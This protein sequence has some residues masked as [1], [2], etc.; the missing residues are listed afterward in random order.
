MVG[1]CEL[2]LALPWQD[3]YTETCFIDE[4][5]KRNSRPAHNRP[6]ALSWQGSTVRLNRFPERMPCVRWSGGVSKS[7]RHTL[8]G[9]KRCRTDP[10]SRSLTV[11]TG[12]V[13]GVDAAGWDPKLSGAGYRCSS[14]TLPRALCQSSIGAG[15]HARVVSHWC[16]PCCATSVPDS[17][18]CLPASPARRLRTKA[19]QQCPSSTQG[20][21]ETIS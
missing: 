6:L 11:R 18:R 13:N 1:S 5:M 17:V 15:C 9:V 20:M 19:M 14:I 10:G 8:T 2:S 7:H 21:G 4:S 16:Y 3:L 12:H